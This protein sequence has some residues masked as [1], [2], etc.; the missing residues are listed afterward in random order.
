MYISVE[1]LPFQ[2]AALS[3]RAVTGL[4]KVTVTSTPDLDNGVFFDG[5]FTTIV[6]AFGAYA[7]VN[8]PG[9]TVG[10]DGQ[11][12]HSGLVMCTA[13]CGAGLGLTSFRMCH[14]LLSFYFFLSLI[15]DSWRGSGISLCEAGEDR[16]NPGVVSVGPRTAEN[17]LFS[18]A[19]VLESVPA[20]IGGGL[21]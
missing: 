8:V 20:G 3:K 5:D 16:G 13:L 10:A 7:V 18:G 4:S 14:F 2:E 6:A 19:E 21:G 11:C 15:C 1:R 12:G 9:A 17:G